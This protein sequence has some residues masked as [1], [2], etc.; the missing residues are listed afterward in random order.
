VIAVGAS[1]TTYGSS[2][3]TP[4]ADYSGGTNWAG[5]SSMFGMCVQAINGATTTLNTPTWTLDST[6]TPGQCVSN[7]LDPW[8][9][10][11]AA[12]VKVASAATPGLS[13]RLDV[14]W[15]ARAATNQAAGRF[16]ASVFIETVAPAV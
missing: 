8:A 13:A 16:S 10:V 3:A 6:N 14:V 1:G 7:D 4:I 12:P 9:A 5:A 15:G 11:P 2:E